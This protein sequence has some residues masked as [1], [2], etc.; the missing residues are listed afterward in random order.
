[1]LAANPTLTL[2][3][4]K[5]ILR[6]TALDWGVGGQDIEYGWGRLDAYAAVKRA[7][8]F[9]GGTAPAV[10]GHVTFAGRITQSGGRA[11]HAVSVTDTGYPMNVT[12]IMP[13]WTGAGTPDLDLYVFA[14]DGSE[15][16]HASGTVR[17]EQ[18]GKPVTQTGNYR[19]EIRAYSGTGDY[20]VDVSAGMGTAP[21]RPP[22][23]SIAQPAEGSTVQGTV[24][25]QVQAADDAPI[26]KVE[27][28]LDDG[29]YT[30]ITPGFNGSV[31]TYA[32]N[33]VGSANGEHTLT[34]RATDSAGQT[35]TAPRRVSVQNRPESP[36]RSQLVTRTGQVTAAAP[37]A[38]VQVNV[39]APGYVDVTLA[40]DSRADLDL[41]VYAPNGSLVGRAYSISKPE[42]FRI[43][44]VLHGTGTYRI[45]INRYEG[46]DAQFTL[47]ASG[48][49]RELFEGSV[50]LGSRNATHQRS[51]GQTGRGRATLRWSSGSDLDFFVYN[52][53]GQEKARAYTLNNPE[54]A[55]VLFD[56]TGAWS[57][58]VNLYAGAAVAY[59]LHLFVPE[60]VLS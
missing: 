23:V 43:D 13:N 45:R 46:P 26:T 60:A 33:T 10:P 19:L 53:T 12:L 30:D 37:D 6:T 21:D 50:S 1:M 3:Q 52:P 31:Y 47:T 16:G 40:W 14:P 24:A 29:A 2:A 9:S 32:W 8:N 48:F 36:P 4:V 15:W 35:A 17:Q 59:A 55:D 18:I 42:R 41:Y 39:F 5:E 27:L 57:V 22:T 20:V 44:T 38:D 7:G 25:V 58:R 28:A 11:E 56:V 54:A 34:A 51:V 49:Q